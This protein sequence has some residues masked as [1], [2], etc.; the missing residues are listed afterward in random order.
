[1]HAVALG[2]GDQQDNRADRAWSGDQRRRQRKDRNVGLGHRLLVFLTGRRGAAGTAREDKV[3][4]DQQQQNTA[5]RA[6]GR[7]SDAEQAKQGVPE[8]GEE[9]QDAGRDQCGFQGDRPPFGGRIARG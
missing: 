3:D 6:Q 5:G 8:K 9:E 7:Q 4:G 2:V 1:L